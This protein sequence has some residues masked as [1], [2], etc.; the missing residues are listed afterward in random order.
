MNFKVQARSSEYYRR[1][2]KVIDQK[3]SPRSFVKGD[4][5]LRN[6]QAT[7]KPVGKLDPKW[8]GP[9]KIAGPCFNGAYKLESLTRKPIPR[10]W[11]AIHLRRFYT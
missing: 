1:I 9:F 7:G 6:V 8:E 4:L 5:V 11:N 3:I 2:E 10:S